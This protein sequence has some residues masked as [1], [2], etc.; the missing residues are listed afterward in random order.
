MKFNLFLHPII[1][2]SSSILFNPFQQVQIALL[3]WW[4]N[5]IIIPSLDI[6]QKNVPFSPALTKIFLSSNNNNDN[7]LLWVSLL[8]V[9]EVIN[10]Y[11]LL[12][13]SLILIV[14]SD[15]QEIILL[16]DKYIKLFIISSWALIMLLSFIKLLSFFIHI[17]IHLSLEQV[18]KLFSSFIDI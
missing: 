17:F 14:S 9:I 15:E 7:K 10:W 6:F 16:L 3:K 2:L 11:L 18:A 1:I 13:N 8:N 4:I 5:L 12:D